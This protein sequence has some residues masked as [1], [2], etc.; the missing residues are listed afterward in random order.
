MAEAP[1]LR[2]TTGAA[3]WI[4]VG[5]GLLAPGCAGLSTSGSLDVEAQLGDGDASVSLGGH[6][7]THADGGAIEV[8][9]GDI[10]LPALAESDCLARELASLRAR[11]LRDPP[12]TA[13]ID[14][15]V[16]AGLPMPP[17]PR[18]AGAHATLMGWSHDALALAYLTA[19]T[20]DPAAAEGFASSL[21]TTLGRWVSYG[22]KFGDPKN[23]TDYGNAPLEVTWLMGNLVRAAHALDARSAA[24]RAAP[25]S[26]V[27]PQ[28][29]A[30]FMKWAH[31]VQSAYIDFPVF[32]AGNSNRK[33]S[34]VE[35]MM[36][37]AEMDGATGEP[38][39]AALFGSLRDL[40]AA[41]ITDRGDIPE[42]SGRDKYHPQFFLA[43]TL[44]TLDIARRHGLALEAA[45]PADQTAIA[46]LVAAL[47]YA[48]DTNE[49]DAPPAEYPQITDPV[50]N[51]DI[52]LWLGARAF[53]DDQSA[54]VPASVERMTSLGYDRPE[55]FGFVIQWGFGAVAR[56]QGL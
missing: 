51:H 31:A 41:G 49:S 44:Q 39:V 25:S 22:V 12:A 26:A 14:A 40:L 32:A 37:I 43:S 27:S 6:P 28:E 48:A 34:Q 13:D 19:T 29:R 54:P 5:L 33:A 38:R 30:S 16:R 20:S 42:D 15:L 7:G 4:V 45:A 56:A 46:H 23:V 9:A 8:D 35:T 47:R 21:K 2:R 53:L 50:A 10:A 24:G 17:D 1:L 18:A 3:A 36:R 52:P 11:P 55:R